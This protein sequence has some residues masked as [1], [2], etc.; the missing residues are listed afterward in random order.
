MKQTLNVGEVCNRVVVFATEDMSLKEAANLMRDEHVGALVVVREATAGRIVTGIL[1]DRD[2]AVVAVARD[3]DPQT[4]RLTDVMSTD[5]LTVRPDD[6][7]YDA[8]A[9]MRQKGVRRVPVTSAAGVLEGLLSFD[10]ILEVVA[11]EL[12]MLVQAISRERLQ[13]EKVRV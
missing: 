9:A 3:F 6:S 12:Q 10:D 1:T 2:I 11:E 5:I 13:E 4:L 7:I 8:L